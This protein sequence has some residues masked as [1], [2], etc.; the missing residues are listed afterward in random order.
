MFGPAFRLMGKNGGLNGK[1]CLLQFRS[2]IHHPRFAAQVLG[3]E[4][5]QAPG[6]AAVAS[7]PS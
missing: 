5:V 2:K 1:E 4:R 7:S 6:T 3:A